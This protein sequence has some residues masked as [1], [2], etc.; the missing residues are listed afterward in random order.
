MD[1]RIPQSGPTRRQ[2]WLALLNKYE[3]GH[4]TS[5]HVVELPGGLVQA[6]AGEP[7][8]TINLESVPASILMFNM[9][10]VQDLRQTRQGRSFVSDVLHGEM[11]LLPRGVPSRW[12]WNSSC[13]RLDV[14]ISPDVFGDGYKRDVVDRFI[15]RDPEMQAVCHR[16]YR[17][18]SHNASTN[19]L[20][21]ESLFIEVARLLFERHST[22]STTRSMPTPSGLARGQVR[23]VLEFIESNLSRQLTLSELARVADLSLHHFARM[24]KSTIGEA[25]HQYVLERRVEHA[26]KM[27]RGTDDSLVEISLSS[28]F[29]S[30]SHFTAT[31]H[32]LMGLTPAQFQERSRKR[33]T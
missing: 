3:V 19:P 31:F 13:D 7:A 22:A 18:L 12:S 20:Y 21:V 4:P 6:T 16:L 10:H 8:G 24:F 5:L 26:K 11:T 1:P 29:C 2:Q 30:Q 27:I 14:I 25:P 28:G 32:R 33:R 15:F 17:E 23:R 9:S